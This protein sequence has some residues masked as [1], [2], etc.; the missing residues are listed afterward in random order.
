MECCIQTNVGKDAWLFG[1]NKMEPEESEE[2]IRMK[3]RKRKNEESVEEQYL[4]QLRE[5]S[6][7]D[8]MAV[9]NDDPP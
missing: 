3:Q 1:R 9:K 2:E 8:V 6:E 5:R 4:R 7:M